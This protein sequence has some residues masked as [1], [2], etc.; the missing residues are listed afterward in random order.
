M[1][2]K[3]GI[4][5]LDDAGGALPRV[6]YSTGSKPGL[7]HG[8]RAAGLSFGFEWRL[9]AASAS[10]PLK[11]GPAGLDAVGGGGRVDGV[12]H[13]SQPGRGC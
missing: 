6:A 13:W 11:A 7:M 9:S 10:M 3:A 2:L 8:G 12:R 5:G 1:L 4:A